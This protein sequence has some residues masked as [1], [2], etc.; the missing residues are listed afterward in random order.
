MKWVELLK[1]IYW[2]HRKPHWNWLKNRARRETERSLCSELRISV[3]R[4]LLEGKKCPSMSIEL[5]DYRIIN[6]RRSLLYL[7][8]LLVGYPVRYSFYTCTISSNGKVCRTATDVIP[9]D[10]HYFFRLTITSPQPPDREGAIILIFTEGKKFYT[11]EP[12]PFLERPVTS[13][14]KRATYFWEADYLGAINI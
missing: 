6:F 5:A 2:K 12:S 14:R 3:F 10:F 1:Q 4:E 13:G 7:K 9:E 11:V 8:G